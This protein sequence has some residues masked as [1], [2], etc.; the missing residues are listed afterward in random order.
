[1]TKLLPDN[2]QHLILDSISC[3]IFTVDASWRITFFNT[4]AEHLTGVRR[5]E[6]LGRPCREVLRGDICDGN[7]ALRETLR[8]G[9]SIVGKPFEL[10]DVRGRRHPVS[11]ST[12]VFKDAEGRPLG[13][14][15]S[16]R[17]LTMVAELRKELSHT[18]QFE[19]IISRSHK[20]RK[21]FDVLT[22]VAETS[23]TVPIEGE[24]GTGKELIS[25]A[26]HSLSSRKEKAFVAVNCAALP[27][28]LL[29]S[30]LFGY[31]A[32]AFTDAF[33]DKPGRIAQAEGGTLLF[34]E[35]GEISPVLQV[36][37]LRF[38]QE[39]T[40]EP[41]GAVGSV[42]ADVR[43]I[44]ATNRDL[45]EL[46]REGRF[47]ED[48]YFRVDV[49]RI[50]VPPL[51]ERMEDIPLLVEHF[52]ERF[53][54][55]QDKKIGGVT[56]DAL[57]LLMAYHYPGNVRELE[58]VIER[59]FVL[60]RDGKIQPKHLPENITGPSLREEPPRCECMDPPPQDSL[61]AEYMLSALKRNNYNCQETAR[62][63]GIHRTTLYR[64]IKRLG[65][66]LSSARNT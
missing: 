36:R 57:D 5:E 65:I 17:D 2:F 3:G 33:R 29:E 60:C 55:I 11:V 23:S 24:T 41:L 46:V 47:R 18:A 63:L 16:I 1:M 61:E 42:K 40:Y 20:M 6:A 50:R 52:I 28:T 13:G 10:I 30:E 19:D 14:V 48:L 26:I 39:H 34:D 15:E 9:K 12:M 45:D 44:A 49:V 8:T 4:A 27:D 31:K 35:I 53:N 56:D 7:C 54:R 62:S 38:L 66:A 37:L 51:R 58:N 21:I 22:M 59:A 25:R 64:K 43:V 32:G